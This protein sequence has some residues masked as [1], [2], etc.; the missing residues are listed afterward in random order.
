MLVVTATSE[1]SSSR[2]NKK[3]VTEL[4]NALIRVGQLMAKQRRWQQNIAHPYGAVFLDFNDWAI[5]ST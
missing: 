1:R 2:P 5:V 4:M 3:P